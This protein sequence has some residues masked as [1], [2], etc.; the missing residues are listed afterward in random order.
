MDQIRVVEARYIA[1]YK[2]EFHFSDKSTKIIDLKNEI[3]GEVFEP[4]KKIENF[5]K[6]KLNHFTIEWEN[7]ADFAPE[8]LFNYEKELV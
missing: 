2:I 5:K 1:D 7:G 6:F 3:Y 4:L 8:F